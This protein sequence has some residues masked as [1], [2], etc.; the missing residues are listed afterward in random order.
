MSIIKKVFNLGSGVS[1]PESIGNYEGYKIT[2][3]Q[4]ITVDYNNLPFVPG[5][6]TGG[7]LYNNTIDN[8]IR[9]KFG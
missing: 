7:N 8:N 1:N 4:N 9:H 3:L 2:N 5:F 6:E